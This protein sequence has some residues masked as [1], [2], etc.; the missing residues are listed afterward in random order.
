[1]TVHFLNAGD[2][3]IVVQFGDIIDRELSTRVLQL[4]RQIRANAVSGVTD[5]VP[6]FRSLLVNY[7]PLQTSASELKARLATL[8]DNVDSQASEARQLIIPVCY[9]GEHAPD[10][11]DVA[12]L[13]GMSPAEVVETHSNTLFH[14]YMLGFVPGYPYMG[15][16]PESL[17]LPRRADPRMRVAPGSVAIASTMTAIY[18]LESP[19]GWHLIGATPVKL[20]DV[21]RQPPALF[22][23]GDKVRFEPVSAAQFQTIRDDVEANHFNV[24]IEKVSS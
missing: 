18:P 13:T 17:V 16:L 8:L 22:R 11:E 6:T 20:F 4:S 19:G 21:E 15:D 3:A 14:V 5:L 12:R 9:E 23:P 10:L 24:L 7:D 2:T 1:M